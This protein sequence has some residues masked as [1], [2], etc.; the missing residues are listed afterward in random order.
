[1]PL[2]PYFGGKSSVSE[3]VWARLG[4]PKQYIEP[5]CGSAAMLLAAPTPAPLEVIGDANGFVA[6]FWRAVK[7]QPRAVSAAADYPVSHVDIYARHR[8]LMEQRQRVADSLQDPN[9]PGDA[10]VAGWWLHGQCNWIGSGWCN[11]DGTIKKAAVD[12]GQVPRLTSAG[13]GVLSIKKHA[14]ALDT[15][16]TVSERLKHVRVIH[17]S[18]DRCLNHTYGASNTAVFLDPPYLGYEDLYNK[19]VG[20]ASSVAKWAA[21]HADL[22]VA[23]CGHVGDYT[24]PG[25]DAVPW[26]RRGATYNGDGTRHAECIWFSP[27]CL[28]SAVSDSEKAA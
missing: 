10:Q 18:W 8:W 24:L 27:S 16:T 20:V 7:N 23:I 26:S 6:N 11:W 5:F 14:R 2:F 28:P 12:N 17:G 19:G 3:M 4:K 13:Q 25:W 1:M 15:L 9:W 21:E 22:R